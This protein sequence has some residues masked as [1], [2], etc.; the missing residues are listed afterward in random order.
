MTEKKERIPHNLIAN[1]IMDSSSFKTISDTDTLLRYNPQSGLYEA[2]GEAFVKTQVEALM[3]K[4]DQAEFATVNF[5]REVVGHIK[6]STYIDRERLNANHNLLVVRNG[7]VVLPEKLLIGHSPEKLFTIG[8]PV[9]YSPSARCPNIEEF[10]RQVVKPENV[11]LLYELCGWC[12]DRKSPIQKLFF[13]L[14]TGANGKS[15]FLNLLRIFL[16][17]ENC[18]SVPLQ[19]L[20]DNRFAMAQLDSKLANTFPDLPASGIKDAAIIKGLTGGDTLLVENKFEKPFNLQNTAKLI[21]SANKA[22]R[23]NEDTDAIW[24]RLVLVDFPHQFMGDKADSDLLDKLTKPEELSGLLN[25]SLDALLRLR[26]KKVFSANTSLSTIRREYLLNSNPVP[27]FVEEMCVK[28]PKSSIS[29]DDLYEAFVRFCEDTG[30]DPIGK[31]AFGGRLNNMAIVI[32]GQDAW[33]T[34]IWKGI[35]LRG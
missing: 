19:A 9:D 2:D 22:P 5:V 3:A 24:R 6:R 8:I 12:L 23:L 11:S 31:K 13:I 29:K 21:F 34:H 26:E 1:K 30:A 14:G 16:G 20:A 32:E 28:D 7:I 17:T 15:T 35:K 4:N 27:V 10:F 25:A 33:Y 18:S